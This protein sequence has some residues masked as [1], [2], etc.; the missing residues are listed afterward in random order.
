MRK[1]H[2][3]HE[4]KSSK[5]PIVLRQ[6]LIAEETHKQDLK[7]ELQRILS[8]PRELLTCGILDSEHRLYKNAQI[9]D[10]ALESV[11]NGM[12]DPSL[13]EQLA[14]VPDESLVGPWKNCVLSLKA[15]YDGDLK[16]L[17][18][19]KDRIPPETPPFKLADLAMMIASGNIP[20]EEKNSLR[21]CFASEILESPDYIVSAGE[22]ME[23]AL[24]MGLI[25]LFADTAAMLV[26]D[27]ERD[28]TEAA[29]DFALWCFSRMAM[30]DH[31]PGPLLKRFKGIFGESDTLRLAALGVAEED[32]D[33][34]LYYWLK[35]IISLLE[36][37]QVDMETLAA[38]LS[39]A[40]HLGERGILKGEAS[41][42]DEQ[43]SEDLLLMRQ[44][45][46]LLN[47]IR[48]EIQQQFPD[49]ETFEIRNPEDCRRAAVLFSSGTDCRI[50][51]H[52]GPPEKEE[53]RIRPEKSE[54]QQLEL[55]A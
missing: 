40:A 27:L 54:P 5:I 14:R 30:D 33:A 9:V 25:D 23:D 39:I 24:E 36:E 53:Q 7:E 19:L 15:L 48:E 1:S 46:K 20:G 2:T 12:E 32:A 26:R 45:Q 55:F 41:G 8:D 3:Q 31:S 49:I 16:K 43:S 21:G 10:D 44:F 17:R 22:Q 35:Y 50:P 51:E 4:H 37:R 13:L 28:Y 47:K 11:T 34:A 52:E 6:L 29:A 38:A 18:A 42:S